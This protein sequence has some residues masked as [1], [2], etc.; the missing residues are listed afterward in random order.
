LNRRSGGCGLSRGKTDSIGS[1]RAGNVLEALLAQIVEPEIEF[2]ADLIVDDS[3]HTNPAR[4]GNSLQSCRDIDA[5][6]V[7]V[8][9]LRDDDVAEIDA[10]P[11]YDPLV[12]RGRDVALDH[13][14]LHRNGA[15]HGLNHARE[16]DE[17]AIAGR[18]DDPALVLGNLRVDQFATMSSEPREGASLVESHEAAVADDIGG[19]NGRESAF[20]PLSAQCVLLE[21]HQAAFE[22]PCG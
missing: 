9:V 14:A 3:R 8:V 11:E 13:P 6:A 16:F 4:F 18:L 20:D 7:D 2:V 22:P 5:I 1:N 19:E 17:D 21:R 12:F 15:G 10:D